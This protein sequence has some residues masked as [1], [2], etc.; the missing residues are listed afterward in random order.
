MGGPVEQDALKDDSLA[1]LLVNCRLPRSA[2]VAD[3]F[4]LLEALPAEQVC[5][6]KSDTLPE[7]AGEHHSQVSVIANSL[8]RFARSVPSCDIVHCNLAEPETW[9]MSALSQVLIAR[10]FGK[11]VAADLGFGF[12][13]KS[14][15]HPPL[16][17]RMI[18]GLCTVA[19]VTSEYA[20]TVLARRGVN[21]VQIPEALA[22]TEF[23]D[24]KVTSVQP[25][26]LTVYPHADQVAAECVVKAFRLAK[27]KYPRTEMTIL[28]DGQDR[29]ACRQLISEG[30]L[31]SITIAA[32]GNAEETASWYAEAD[33]FVNSSVAG[34]LR[35]MLKAMA[36]GLPVV[37]AAG[38]YRDELIVDRRNGLNFRENEPG[39]LADRIIELIEAP[40]LINELT[41]QARLTV[42]DLDWSK[43][44]PRWLTCYRRLG[45]PRRATDVARTGQHSHQPT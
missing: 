39:D 18:L 24:R 14:F 42:V 30:E 16:A 33:M 36:S 12:D 28:A 11:A 13:E 32:T 37:S 6:Q 10:F 23:T 1:I 7:V 20:A 26:I 29:V 45:R 9:T 8:R 3:R 44:S 4:R 34:G 5:F 21:A 27:A 19:I 43:I 41:D 25:Q 2:S 40:E 15:E 22:S 31:S 35:P 38:F 17:L